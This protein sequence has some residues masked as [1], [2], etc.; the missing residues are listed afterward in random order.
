[1]EK[2]LFFKSCLGVF[3]G[4]GCRAAAFAGA[5]EEAIRRG[6]SFSEVAGTSAGSIVAALIGA[7][8]TAA[9]VKD[10]LAKLNFKS[11]LQEPDRTAKRG[12]S[13]ARLLPKNYA[14]LYFDQGF[15]SSV[16]IKT[17]MEGLLFELLP[18]E[19]HPIAF[20]SLPFPTY[21]VSTDLARSEAKVWS[22]DTTPD[23]LVSE[24]VRASCTIP[25]YFQPINRRHIDGGLL[26][27]LPAFVFASRGTLRR[28]LASKILAFSLISED[29]VAD[30]W[31][32]KGYLLH[33]VST[34]VDGGARLQLDL[35]P[36]VH[37]INIPTGNVRAT[38]FDKM[39]PKTIQKLADGGA[40]A[41]KHFFD[42]EHTYVRTSSQKDSICFD[43]DEFYCRIT[44]AIEMNTERLIVAKHNTAWVYKL[45]PTILSLRQRGVRIDVILP[46]SGDQPGDGPYRRRLLH[47][48][49]ANVTLVKGESYVPPRATIIIPQDKTQTKVLVGVE[50]QPKSDAD[51]VLYQGYLDAGVV[52]AT[53][54]KL[55]NQIGTV[56]LTHE[57]PLLTR[58]PDSEIIQSLRRVGQYASEGVKL[59]I[60]RVEIKQLVA[61]SRLT[62]EFKYN[63]IRRLV[64]LYRRLGLEL[65]E[66]AAIQ[67]ENGQR[68]IV[69]PP[70]VEAAGDKFVLIEG[71]TRATFCRDEGVTSFKCVVARGVA[72][73]T[74]SR[75]YN[76]ER[77]R[78][79]GRDLPASE[80]YDGFD[81]AH[82]RHIERAMH[83]IDGLQ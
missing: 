58:L 17:W 59:S 13:L 25:I 37:V 42:E 52:S 1:M 43:K 44:Q 41:T 72:D 28:S 56:Q 80:R 67:L 77:V 50:T 3:Q 14:D 51:A 66:P 60:E 20:K 29:E 62:R 19:Q 61:T 70:V 73:P 49:G 53:L 23:E 4:G 69:T 63:Q 75:T 65:F 9:F 74:P 45:L 21:I 22:Q 16:V 40:L 64:D 15:H 8:A 39:T 46:E 38:D 68:S 12:L 32:T 76:F 54:E 2:T 27:N 35:Q 18:Q 81:Y 33:L 83:P 79:T 6:V 78:I 26:S 24:A 30:K 31:D 36:N 55:E 82:F 48:L 71:S 57:P 5:Y 34:L 47:A 7:G 10:E 11:F